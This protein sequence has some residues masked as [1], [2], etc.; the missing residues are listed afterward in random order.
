MSIR[1]FELAKFRKEFDEHVR[2]VILYG[3]TYRILVGSRRAIL[4]SDRDY[5]K[6]R[7]GSGEKL[8]DIGVF[9]TNLDP[10]LNEVT[11]YNYIYRIATPT[12]RITLLSE[13]TY[14]GLLKK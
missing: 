3:Y 9:K 7:K 12:G 10:T 4:I 14:D 1:M 13:Y 6:I 8:M 2:Q 11:M 5:E